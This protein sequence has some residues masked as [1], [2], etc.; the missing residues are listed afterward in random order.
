M[1]LRHSPESIN[2]SAAS[3]RS[4]AGSNIAALLI[5]ATGM[6][7]ANAASALE[8]PKGQHT[9]VTAKADGGTK[10]ICV[11]DASGSPAKAKP[12]AKPVRRK[13]AETNS[14]EEDQ[15]K[16]I[17][18]A[19]TAAKKAQETAEANKPTPVVL[20]SAP[21]PVVPPV[22]PTP[23]APVVPPVVVPPAVVPAEEGEADG[24]LVVE[25]V[26]KSQFGEGTTGAG[27]NVSLLS[28]TS[29]KS[30]AGVGFGLE[31]T[32]DRKMSIEGQE[33]AGG[34]STVLKAGLEGWTRVSGIQV[35][36]RAG[37]LGEF[38]DKT[39]YN[40][41][42]LTG[43]NSVGAYAEAGLRFVMNITKKTRGLVG[44]AFGMTW[45][46]KAAG[47]EAVGLQPYGVVSIG[48]AADKVD[49]KK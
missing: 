22:A 32:S 16:A 30:S 18:E 6:T 25:G 23:P 38:F 19:L 49:E 27:F 39:V 21:T 43:E 28:S 12:A 4:A 41:K 20:P 3:F 13:V 46:Q 42:A 26:A 37:A 14:H 40:N 17:A 34:R 7:A 47:S 1:A 5:A 45:G 9:G 29:N 24:T 2:S 10:A 11:N 35:G 44:A 8:C 31:R 15:N 36:A 33:V 48:F